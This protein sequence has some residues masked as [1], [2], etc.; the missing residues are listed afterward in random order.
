MTE[1]EAIYYLHTDI[2]RESP[3]SDD[4]TRKALSRIPSLPEDARVM[5]LGCGPGRASLVLATSLNTH[6]TAVDLHEPYLQRLAESAKRGGLE[7]L[8]TTR[9]GDMGAL[10]EDDGTIDLIWSEGAIYLL[11]FEKGLCYWR[12]LLRPGGIVVV[13]ELTRLAADPD[14]VTFWAD[15]YP[16]LTT[17]DGNRELAGR[18]GFEVIDH[19]VMP[20]SCWWDNYLTPLA[21]RVAAL[22]AEAADNPVLGAVLDEA[23]AEAEA[24][25]RDHE[26]IGYV[27]YIMRWAE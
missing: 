26:S 16:A 8:I 21:A 25:R 4:A 24:Y 11:G 15:A 9:V 14:A 12:Q 20:E 6:V 7:Q 13:S 5:D 10:T 27:F 22:R 1:L 17:I 18:A 19:F 2:P 23:E 3:G